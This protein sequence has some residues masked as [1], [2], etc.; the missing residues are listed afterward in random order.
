[1]KYSFA[2]YPEF[3][4]EFKR[5]YKKYPSLKKDLERF[6]EEYLANPVSVGVDLGNGIRKVRM[7]IASKG[8]GKSHGARVITLSLILSE[9]ETEIGLHYIYDKSEV[10]SIT[11]RQIEDILKWNRE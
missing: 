7:S 10:S 6:K 5:L 8:K 2:V 11:D 1:M 3:A 9:N 4:R